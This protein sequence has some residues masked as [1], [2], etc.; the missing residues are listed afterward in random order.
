MPSF[1]SPRSKALSAASP[2]KTNCAIPIGK[3][4]NA[5]PVTPTSGLHG[6]RLELHFSMG[7]GAYMKGDDVVLTPLRSPLAPRN[8]YRSAPDDDEAIQQIRR[9]TKQVKAVILLQTKMRVHLLE[10]VRSRQTPNIANLAPDE[11]ERMDTA[12]ANAIVVAAINEAVRTVD[13]AEIVDICNV[14][15]A[16]AVA[17][18]LAEVEPPSQKDVVQAALNEQFLALNDLNVRTG[19]RT[20][21]PAGRRRHTC[22]ADKIMM[23][24]GC[25]QMMLLFGIMTSIVQSLMADG[26]A[27]KKVLKPTDH[28][29]MHNLNAEILLADLHA[30]MLIASAFA[31]H[32]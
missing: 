32:M 15:V 11:P 2:S 14:V 27:F 21:S 23:L 10:G 7:K 9:M 31:I 24:V 29:M 19:H 8:V 3:P 20:S 26:V 25:L 6:L 18:A 4:T 1:S 30:E 22:T 16:R 28:Q 5:A 17:R 13:D 12:L